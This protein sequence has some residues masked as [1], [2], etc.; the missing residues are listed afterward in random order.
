ML[1]HIL[2]FREAV[3]DTILSLRPP[4]LAIKCV[5]RCTRTVPGIVFRL[6]NV[7]VLN[8]PESDVPVYDLS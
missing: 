6:Y 7:F 4:P 3:F 5:I 1:T 2:Q 8:Q